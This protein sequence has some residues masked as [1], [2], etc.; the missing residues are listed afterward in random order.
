MT[1][2]TYPAP[3]SQV[4]SS[5]W[6]Y[7]ATGGE[8]TLTGIDNA[9]VSLAYL[10]GQE[11][12]FL[13]GVMLMRGTDYTATN[14]TSIVGLAALTASDYV[15]VTTYSNFTINQVPV[16]SLQGSIS[17]LQLA[18]SSFTIGSTL[19]NLGDTKT[20][21]AGLTLTSP[22]I[23]NPIVGTGYSTSVPLTVKGAAGQ[24]VNL[25]EWNINGGST[26]LNIDS[27]GILRASQGMY[28]MDEPNNISNNTSFNIIRTVSGA[29]LSGVK[30]ASNNQ[31]DLLFNSVYSAGTATERMRIS[32]DGTVYIGLNNP[33]AGGAQ[34]RGLYIS[35][36]DGA[37]TPG[38]IYVISGSSSGGDG[39]TI[40]AVGQRSDGNTSSVF[41][42]NLALSHLR[43]DAVISSA[44]NNLGRIMFGGNA[45]GT[46]L[47]SVRYSAQIVGVSDGTWSSSSVMPTAL[48]FYTGSSGI[49]TSAVSETGTER[50]RI[51]SSGKV[52]IGTSGP[53][54]LLHIA[55]QATS[56]E[57]LGLHIQNTGG[58]TA[59]TTFKIGEGTPENQYGIL[60]HY[61]VDNSFRI[62]NVATTGGYLS[63]HNTTTAGTQLTTGERMRLES[64]N[65]YFL[66]GYTTSNGAYKLQVNS[67][68]FATSASIATS[69]G[70]FKENVNTI[71]N[72]L[73][74]VDALNPVSFNWKKHDKHDFV[75]GKTV[76]FIAQEVRETLKDYEW[77]DNVVKENRDGETGEEFLG[78][79][80]SAIIPLLVSAVK[81]LSA[82][83]KALEAK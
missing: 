19:I 57:V 39:A 69:D 11:Q 18:N 48:A 77:V 5:F 36:G 52:G 35:S 71:N 21:I 56:G 55:Q 3:K 2:Q 74:L 7:T 38:G 32:T 80:D 75:E 61:G 79:V 10:P 24:A 58:G 64:S 51:D 15:Q 68:I 65:G 27:S 59:V 23:N 41:S 16:T 17:N 50:M 45:T 83:V 14:G 4:T 1:V 60:G 28:S 26:L 49:L 13:N 67:Q 78:L 47:S 70:R 43:T 76:G 54:S 8:T 73:Q 20:T 42:G 22:T 72:G 53:D 44:G 37:G 63:F 30:G 46:T 33:P 40:E 81:E 62:G 6:R 9:G 66:V 12:V 31:I 25:Q 29:G 82:K 34:K